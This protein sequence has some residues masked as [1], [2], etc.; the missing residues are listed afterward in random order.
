[1]LT[2]YGTRGCHLCE[3]AEA[4][5]HQ[6]GSARALRWQSVDIALDDALVAA[7]GERLPVLR[8]DDGRELDW[9]FSLLDV[10]ALA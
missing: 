7:Y 9:P 8:K 10:L 4:L 2:L 6:A 5:L 1:M 3:V